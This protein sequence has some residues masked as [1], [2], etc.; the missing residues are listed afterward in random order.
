MKKIQIL[1]SSNQYLDSRI[2]ILEIPKPRELEDLRLYVLEELDFSQLSELEIF[3]KVMNWVSLRWKH[4]G[5]NDAGDISSLEILNRAS[6]GESFRC[7][8]YA[9]V[10]KDILLSMGYIA[11]SI[12][13]Q[14]ENAD[15]GGFGQSHVVTEVWSN[16]LKKWIFFDPQLNCYA[17]VNNIPLSYYEVF[18]EFKDT[19]FVF[20]DKEAKIDEK[21]YRE[22]IKNYFGYIKIECMLN[23]IKSQ[24]YLHLKGER[25]LLAFQAMPLSN[26]I[27]TTK[28]GNI[29]FNPNNTSILFEYKDKVDAVKII[30]E[31]N[32]NSLENIKENLHLFC[33]KPN[34]I[35]KFITN[36]PNFDY[37]E[38]QINEDI[39]IKIKNNEYD[40][41]VEEGIYNISICSVNKQGVKGSITTMKIF[42]G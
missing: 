8:E 23:G 41:S 15:Y 29:Y 33:V 4:D 25:Q 38:L 20:L 26:A 12:S 21:K 19:S 36:T 1:E 9:K 5:I 24:L 39:L 22:F 2:N 11:R 28:I 30:K 3:L 14:S 17:T 6:K 10:A 18:K 40:W 34:F 13:I 42:Y 27:F 7:V 16:E 31:N 32:F 35:L 37:Y